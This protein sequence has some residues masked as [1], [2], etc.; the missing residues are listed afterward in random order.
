MNAGIRMTNSPRGWTQ[1][2]E[3]LFD[4]N[5]FIKLEWPTEISI[6]RFCLPLASMYFIW[7][8]LFAMVVVS[9]FTLAFVTK[10]IQLK[11]YAGSATILFPLS[12]LSLSLGISLHTMTIID[13]VNQIKWS[14]QWKK[15]RSKSMCSREKTTIS[16]KDC[17]R[18]PLQRCIVVRFQL[19]VDRGG[20][21][22]ERK[23]CER[24]ELNCLFDHEIDVYSSIYIYI[25]GTE[26][27]NEC[28]Y[29]THFENC[30][31]LKY[32]STSN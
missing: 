13:S 5:T 17:D 28:V 9:L 29:S 24:T 12:P 26:S 2:D 18:I 4:S 20:R 32:N 10:I 8:K 27:K 22:R 11:N 16:E 25:F 21:R 6:F 3:K 14:N 23:K 19:V 30:F 15:D 7:E 31:L 1:Y